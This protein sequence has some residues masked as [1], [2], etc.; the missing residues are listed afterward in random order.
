M[1]SKEVEKAIEKLKETS[2]QC[3]KSKECWENEA[4]PDCYVEIEDILAI[5]TV[6]PYISELEEKVEKYNKQLDLDYV[7]NNFISKAK[8]KE[9][10]ES[11]K[12]MTNFVNQKYYNGVTSEEMKIVLSYISEL[13]T[14]C[15][16]QEYRIIEMDIPKQMIRDKIEELEKE[17]D[18]YAGREHAEWQDGEFDGDVCDDIGLKIGVLKEL[19]GE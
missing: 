4:C 13:E 6:L 8:I 16:I 19:L 10:K 15:K 3:H 5:D 9:V 18:F 2:Q 11:I 1:R 7:D 12:S 17:L 14:R